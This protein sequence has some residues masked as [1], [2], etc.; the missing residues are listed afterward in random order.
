M[1]P[2]FYVAWDQAGLGKG[3]LVVAGGQLI[4]LGEYGQLLLARATP[5]K[6]TPV[7]RCQVF[8][9]GILTWTVPVVSGGRL[10]V[11]SEKELLT[12]GVSAKRR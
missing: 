8:G 5:A 4:I 11:R 12:L 7:S 3:A 6:F 2:L 1:S 9:D 10:F